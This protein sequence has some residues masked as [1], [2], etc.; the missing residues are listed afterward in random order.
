LTA[1]QIQTAINNAVN[2]RTV[3]AVVHIR[4]GTYNIN[5]TLVVLASSDI[6]IVAAAFIRGSSRAGWQGLSKAALDGN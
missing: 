5:T 4:T 6:Q 1:A 2:S 3:K